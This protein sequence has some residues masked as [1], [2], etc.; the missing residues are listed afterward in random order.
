MISYYS[1]LGA[2]AIASPIARMASTIVY[3]NHPGLLGAMVTQSDTKVYN[4]TSRLLQ[5]A[6]KDLYQN[7]N[8]D[9]TKFPLPKKQ[10]G[11]LKKALQN[12]CEKGK[13]EGIHVITLKI[14][15]HE[16]RL[17]KSAIEAG[18]RHHQA[19]PH[20]SQLNYCLQQHNEEACP[21]PKFRSVSIGVSAVVFSKG[22]EKVL[23]VMEKKGPIKKVK[24]PTGTV[25]YGEPLQET[26]LQCV[27]RELEEETGIIVDPSQSIFAGTTWSNNYR[28]THPDIS[29]IFAF[30]LQNIPKTTIQEDEISKAEWMP[31]Q[32]FLKKPP[33][34]KEKPWMLRQTVKVALR[35]LQTKHF[36]SQKTFYWSNGKPVDI[37]CDVLGLEEC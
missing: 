22:L 26:P 2:S 21:Y 30:V 35:A 31:V 27:V 16:G 11:V 19:N 32:D 12:V 17:M 20:F 36:W 9:F 28:G 29:Y 37:F 18:F 15:S 6:Q 34:E 13:K 10:D 24:P 25:D 8:I 14:P 33:E 1:C 5:I 7:Y 4:L 23:V 3:S